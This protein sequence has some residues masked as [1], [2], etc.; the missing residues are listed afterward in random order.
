[1]ASVTCWTTALAV[2]D[3]VRTNPLNGALP[4]GVSASG[5]LAYLPGENVTAPMSLVAANRNGPGEVLLD[6]R[7]MPNASMRLSPDGRRLAL[8]IFD[9]QADIWILAIRTAIPLRIAGISV[10]TRPQ[11]A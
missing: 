11:P 9:G 7:L 5:L 4:V 2:R 6:R 1:M 8:T 3:N 10:T